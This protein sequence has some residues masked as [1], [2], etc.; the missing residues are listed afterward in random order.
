MKWIFSAAILMIAV[1]LLSSAEPSVD[2]MKEYLG[3]Y[4]GTWEGELSFET[5]SGETLKTLAVATEYWKSGEVTKGM[6]AFELVGEINFAKS[7]TYFRNN[8]LF[9]DVTQ[10]GKTVTYRGFLRN[11]GIVWI[12]YDAELNTERRITER[13][14]E[15]GGDAVLYV[16][17]QELIRSMEGTGKVLLRARLIRK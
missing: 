11:G 2:D 16:E 3:Q 6:T 1:P 13:F 5:P 10:N 14:A 8:L 9:S 15:E 17:G 12:P 7:K 4:L